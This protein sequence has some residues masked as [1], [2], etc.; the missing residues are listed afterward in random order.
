MKR[1]LFVLL[2]MTCSV[3]WAEW[4][5]VG[6]TDSDDFVYYVDRVTIRKK[7]NF[8]EMWDMTNYFETQVSQ[9]GAKKYKSRKVLNRYDCTDGTRGIVS[10]LMY[11][12]ENGKG[13]VVLSHIV[14]KNEIEDMPV[15]P[16]SVAEDLW[17]IACRRK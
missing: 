8:I 3:S 7:G 10:F 13:N 1:I 9:V 16:E 6:K 5:R 12:E 17:K 2:L 11:A 15:S 14:K 4:E